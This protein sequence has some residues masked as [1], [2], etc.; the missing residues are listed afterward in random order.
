MASGIPATLFI[1]IHVAISLVGMVVALAVI[2]EK[3]RRAARRFPKII[4]ERSD[5]AIPTKLEW[6]Q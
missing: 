1:Q 6:Q 3:D 5:D 4:S 2:W